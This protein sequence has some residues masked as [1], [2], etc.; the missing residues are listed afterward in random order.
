M[1]SFL[2]VVFSLMLPFFLFTRHKNRLENLSALW[3]LPV[4]PG[5]CAA[6]TGARVSEQCGEGVARYVFYV[7]SYLW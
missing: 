1:D 7:S 4:L 2:A 5:L 6:S 3:L